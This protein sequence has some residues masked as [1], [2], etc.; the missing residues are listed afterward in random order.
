MHFWPKNLSFFFLKSEKLI[1]SFEF[2]NLSYFKDREKIGVVA[3]DLSEIK[4]TIIN[5][6]YIEEKK[7]VS[8]DILEKEINY[9][10]NSKNRIIELINEILSEKK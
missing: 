1:N 3:R 2:E 4:N 6:K 10:G 7:K 9:L 5:I 8:N